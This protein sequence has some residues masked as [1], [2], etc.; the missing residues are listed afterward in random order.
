MVDG[1]CIEDENEFRGWLKM[2]IAAQK[3]FLK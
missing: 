3:Y 1:I 2:N